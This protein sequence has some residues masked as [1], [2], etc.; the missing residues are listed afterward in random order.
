MCKHYKRYNTAGGFKWEFENP[1]HIN[2][3]SYTDTI[4]NIIH[5]H[6]N[7]TK[8][9]M[10]KPKKWKT[11][12][13]KHPLFG[14]RLKSKYPP[15]LQYDLEDKLIKEWSTIIDLYKTT[16]YHFSFILQTIKNNKGTAYG[17]KWKFKS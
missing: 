9:L 12:D 13:G 3:L 15:I 6:S 16:N 17:F 4:P 5:K 11:K 7:D 8:I 10:S 1:E 2:K 14:K